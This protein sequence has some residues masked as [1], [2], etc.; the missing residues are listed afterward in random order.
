MEDYGKPRRIVG[1]AMRDYE[2]NHGGLWGEPWE[3]KMN[4]E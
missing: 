3:R 4:V 1:G 2:S